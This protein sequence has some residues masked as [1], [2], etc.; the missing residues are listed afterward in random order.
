LAYSGFPVKGG[1]I[2]RR[3]VTILLLNLK[4]FFR[5]P[6]VLV[7]MFGM[8]ILFSAIF[9]G[10]AVKSE[11][12][13]PVV[14]V[15]VNNKEDSQRI[16]NLLKKENHFTWKKENI[17]QA[18]NNVS[19]EDAV[20][21]VVIPDNIIERMNK[22]QP[23][24]EIILQRKTQDY[25]ALEPHLQGTARLVISSYQAIETVKEDRFPQLLQ[26]IANQKG[27]TVEQQVV[28]KEKNNL[29]DINLMFTGFT[30]MFMMFGLSGAAST[31][32]NERQSGTWAR[33]IIS[34]VK[35]FE[36]TLGYLLAYFLMGWIQFAFIMISMNLMFDTN[37]GR[38]SYLIPFASLVIITIVGLGLMIAGLVKTQQ[39]A[40]AIGAVLIV[41]TCM[42]G[43][44][45]WPIDIMPEYMQKIALGVPQSWA[46]S[47]FKEI[48]SGSLHAGTLWKD[49][50]VLMGFSLLFFFFG[51]R[52]IK[53]E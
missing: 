40:A 28:Q 3:I 37:W 24:F 52:G 53:F 23:L 41:S 43:G 22:K 21:A 9:G 12:V 15:V 4:K 46:M 36:V 30:I 14:D 45:Y 16:F 29:T 1:G 49:S 48:I 13:K 26:T 51:I 10:I 19:K 42:L 33:I 35:K 20:A 7:L 18:K 39:Q 5:S 32:L 2:M 25:L 17:A 38:L 50:F 27:V 44:L 6:G 34:P 11:Q 8:P 31:I 47:G